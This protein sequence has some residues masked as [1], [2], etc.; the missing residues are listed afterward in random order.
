MNK[1]FIKINDN[2]KYI[3][4]QLLGVI[5]VN[6][7]IPVFYLA[8]GIIILFHA[9]GLLLFILGLLGYDVFDDTIRNFGFPDLCFVLLFLGICI[10]FNTRLIIL[11]VLY[12]KLEKYSQSKTVRKFIYLLKTDF[13][14]KLFLSGGIEVISFILAYTYF[15]KTGTNLSIQQIFDENAVYNNT[16][17]TIYALVIAFFTCDLFACYLVLFLW[18]KIEPIVLKFIK[19]HIRF[20]KQEI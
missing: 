14:F 20:K 7:F 2:T 17:Q 4:L 6:L 10:F 11:P 18:W 12:S 8:F 3:D 15:L 1:I 13:L 16:V 5:A 9:T 19:L